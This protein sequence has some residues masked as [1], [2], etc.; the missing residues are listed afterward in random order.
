[1]AERYASIIE[2]V[3]AKLQYFTIDKHKLDFIRNDFTKF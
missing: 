3:A 1:M 2:V